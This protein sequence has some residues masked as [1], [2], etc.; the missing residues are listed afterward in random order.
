MPPSGGPV[1]HQPV[2]YH[3]VLR[4]LKPE[5]PG[6]YI[7]A[8]VGAGGHASGILEA[9]S[10]SGQLL[11]MDLDPLALQLAEDHLSRF[12]DRFTLK[13]ASYTTLLRQMATVGW[14]Q[15]NGIL[16]D[17]G[18]SSMQ[19]DRPEKGFSFRYEAP[20]DM[21]F[22]P[23]QSLTAEQLVNTLSE[24]ALADLLWQYGEERHSRRIAHVIVRN[25]P[26]KTTT[27]LADLIQRIIGRHHQAI[28]PA[29][30]TFQALRIAVNH[31]LDALRQVLPDIIIALGKGGRAA[32]ITFHSLEDR[33]VKQFFQKESQNCICPPKQPVCTCNHTA[34]L[35]IVEKRIKPSEEEIHNNPRARSATL[36]VIEK[37]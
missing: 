35:K 9:S 33:I 18:I 13:Q 32:I 34:S 20:L 17:L 29:T 23:D 16:L 25:R 27:E 26:L 10:P 1:P 14:G 2:L 19:L 12:G 7:D 15:T 28:H 5:S 30:R 36:R 11:G 21:R 22:N 8:T 24:E 37:I 6:R 4:A 3:E 31:E